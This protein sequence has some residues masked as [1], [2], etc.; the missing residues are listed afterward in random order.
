MTIGNGTKRNVG[1]ASYCE[2]V[3]LRLQ[4]T[5]VQCSFCLVTSGFKCHYDKMSSQLFFQ[6]YCPALCQACPI[7]ALHL[8]SYIAVINRVC[9]HFSFLY[10]V[11]VCVCVWVHVR[12]VCVV[13]GVRARVL[14]VVCVCGVCVCVIMLF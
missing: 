7:D 1:L 14:C 2:P 3:F 13:C 6:S 8:S 10:G 9:P 5:R 4:Y 12:F 11:C